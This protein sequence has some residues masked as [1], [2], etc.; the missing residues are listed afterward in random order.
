[1]PMHTTMKHCLTLH[2]AVFFQN[3]CRG[4]LV[5]SAW[6][7]LLA[8]GQMGIAKAGHGAVITV[9]PASGTFA[10][11][12]A[13]HF[14]RGR[15]SCPALSLFLMHHSVLHVCSCNEHG[16]CKHCWSLLHGARKHRETLYM[17]IL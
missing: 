5:L 2:Y 14:C 10:T 4:S 9:Y 12:T 11:I 7:A 1:M 16:V 17:A 15:S 8:N 6:Y 3:I 13:R